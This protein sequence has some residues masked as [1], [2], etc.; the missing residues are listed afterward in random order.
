ML[1]GTNDNTSSVDTE[2][3]EREKL[4]QNLDFCVDKVSVNVIDLKS[5][6]LTLKIKKRECFPL[7]AFSAKCR[8]GFVEHLSPT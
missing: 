8:G 1:G 5:M 2:L 4:I 3:T 7:P 6:S